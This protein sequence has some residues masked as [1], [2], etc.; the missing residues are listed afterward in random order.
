M[1]SMTIKLNK[2]KTQVPITHH[3]LLKARRLGG[4]SSEAEE[5][6]IIIIFNDVYRLLLLLL[7]PLFCVLYSEEKEGGQP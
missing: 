3:R 4:R 5:M 2:D 1:I 6:G 7:H